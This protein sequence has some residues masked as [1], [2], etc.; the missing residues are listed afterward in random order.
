[1]AAPTA[2]EPRAPPT[3]VDTIRCLVVQPPRIDRQALHEESGPPADRTVAVLRQLFQELL[4]TKECVGRPRRGE[5]LNKQGKLF[6][7]P[8]G[9]SCYPDR[10]LTWPLAHARGADVSEPRA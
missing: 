3:T 1:M 10:S 7:V 8:H 4:V 5:G 9:L 6:F 2:A